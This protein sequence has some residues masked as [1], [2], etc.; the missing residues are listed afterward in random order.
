MTSQ[1]GM[2]PAMRIAI[3]LLLVLIALGLRIASGVTNTATFAV[4]ALLIGLSALVVIASGIQ[5]LMR[6][7]R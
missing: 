7:R 4:L 2:T 3:G 1:T 6:A 5:G